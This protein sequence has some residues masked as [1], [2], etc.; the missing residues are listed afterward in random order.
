MKIETITTPE[1]PKAIGPY[2]QALKVHDCHS[3][4]AAG[5]IF[6]SGQL[7]MDPESAIIT[8]Q[9]ISE[10]TQRC[11]MNIMAILK[12]ANATIN[13]ILKVTVFMTDLAGFNEFNSVYEKFMGN[14][15]PARACVQVNALPK[16]AMIE[17][18]AIA[19]GTMEDEA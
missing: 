14:H 1:A 10:Q 7:P 3:S 12:A 16:G 8:G 4:I 19:L 13:Q 11:L 5:L 17:I 15:K 2:S 6:V 9:N 18:D